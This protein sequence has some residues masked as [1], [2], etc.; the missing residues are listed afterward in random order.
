M[1]DRDIDNRLA[2]G[3]ELG[4]NSESWYRVTV[5][6][7]GTLPDIPFF[8]GQIGNAYPDF[9]C[10]VSAC[11]EGLAKTRAMSIYPH[12]LRG[13]LVGYEVKKI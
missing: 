7:D 11:R 13:E 2:Y 12:P 10:E 1:I 3:D 8:E 9:T 6:V 4:S 5:K